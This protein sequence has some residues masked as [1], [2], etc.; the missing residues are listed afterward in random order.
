MQGKDYDSSSRSN[1]D[2]VE[3]VR[4]K[5]SASI[6]GNIPKRGNANPKRGKLPDGREYIIGGRNDP[7]VIAAKAAR[8]AAGEKVSPPTKKSRSEKRAGETA[9]LV[10]SQF[11]AA[12]SG[13][14][15]P[16]PTNRFGDFI[17]SDEIELV[18]KAPA[19][20]KYLDPKKAVHLGCF[21]EAGRPWEEGKGKGPGRERGKPKPGTAAAAAAKSGE[22]AAVGLDPKTAAAPVLAAPLL[23]GLGKNQKTGPAQTADRTENGKRPFR[24]NGVGEPGHYQYAPEFVMPLGSQGVFLSWDLA[25]GPEGPDHYVA[26]VEWSQI[27]ICPIKRQLVM[28]CK[29]PEDYV[30]HIPIL[31]EEITEEKFQGLGDHQKAR[32]IVDQEGG[33]MYFPYPGDCVR[34]YEGTG[35]LNAFIGNLA[36]AVTR[37]GEAHNACYRVCTQEERESYVLHSVMCGALQSGLPPWNCV[38]ILEVWGPLEV[39]SVVKVSRAVPHSLA[40]IRA[41]EKV[42]DEIKHLDPVKLATTFVASLTELEELRRIHAALLAEREEKQ[43]MANSGETSAASAISVLVE[44]A[45]RQSPGIS[46]E[47]S[48]EDGDSEDRDYSCAE[49][50]DSGGDES[51]PP[52][53][54]PVLEISE[55]RGEVAA[56]PVLA[57]AAKN[58]ETENGAPEPKTGGEPKPGP[59]QKAGPETE[60]E[61][62]DYEPDDME[63]VN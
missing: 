46:D 21:A 37:D 24:K 5:T 14:R 42:P 19:K 10:Q 23:A 35:F 50:S 40:E 62:A 15:E 48:S 33:K 45:E 44:A 32:A 43:R 28:G 57:A 22:T 56:A 26:L 13:K 3:E 60:E 27:R 58:G 34:T 38:A 39:G 47:R 59:V 55:K 9:V 6:P 52:E 53:Q 8:A 51:V 31:A 1:E 17:D 16:K 11:E 4:S 12:P 61:M 54:E 29:L 2:S 63:E 41:Y 30:L 7:D 49:P 25:R 18:E 20:E 36:K